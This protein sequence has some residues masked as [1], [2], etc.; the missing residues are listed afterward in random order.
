MAVLNLGNRSP[1]KCDSCGLEIPPYSGRVVFDGRAG[2]AG[3]CAG[4]LVCHREECF[5]VG[6]L[7]VFPEMRDGVR[8]A[9]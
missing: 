6:T 4:F 1:L 2:S 7:T 3:P 5:M 8:E 9:L